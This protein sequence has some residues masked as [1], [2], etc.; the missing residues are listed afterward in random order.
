MINDAGQRSFAFDAVTASLHY[1]GSPTTTRPFPSWDGF[2]ALL[3][4]LH[5]QSHWRLAVADIHNMHLYFSDAEADPPGR[6][7]FRPGPHLLHW[8]EA[9]DDRGYQ[10]TQSV[11]GASQQTPGSNDCAIGVMAG[12]VRVARG[13]GLPTIDSYPPEQLTRMRAGFAASTLHF[14]SPPTQG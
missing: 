11:L 9:R 5:F 12:M 4:P 14:S 8:L 10:W 6:P 7:P 1:Q 13:A 3:F 2:D